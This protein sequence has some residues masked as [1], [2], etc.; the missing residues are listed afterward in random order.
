MPSLTAEIDV[1]AVEKVAE[2]L[3]RI[4]ARSLGEAGLRSVNRTLTAI[5]PKAVDLMI[6][7]INLSE[8]EVRKRMTFE[9]ANDPL[10][11]QASLIAKQSDSRGTTLASYGARILLQ[12]VNWP[13]GSFI[14]YRWGK[15]PRKPGFRMPWFPRTGD[16]SRGIPANQ[17]AAGFTASVRRG[18]VTAFPT[19]NTYAIL[20]PVGG[21]LLPVHINRSVKRGKGRLG[22]AVYGPSVRQLFKHNLGVVAKIAEDDLAAN[23]ANEVDLVVQKAFA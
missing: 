23:L 9:S 8:G 13:N 17:K 18:I 4:D 11:P 14:P 22:N 3:L 16:P 6:G 20:I 7:G 1:R 21:R 5:Y 19:A 10:K 2:Q 12:G 15:N